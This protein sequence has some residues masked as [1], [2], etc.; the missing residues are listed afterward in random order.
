MVNQS[1]LNTYLNIQFLPQDV[2]SFFLDLGLVTILAFLLSKI[3]VKYGNSLSNRKAFSNNFIILG[4]T[5]M[6]IITVVKASL[7]LSLGLVGALSIVRFRSAIKEPEELAYLFLVISLG[8][9]I[10]AGQRYVTLLAFAFICLIL[11]LRGI[12]TKTYKEQNLFLTISS[13]S[14]EKV[15]LTQIVDTLK[16]SASLV[17]LRRSDRTENSMELVLYVRFANLAK[18]EKAEELLRSLDK[19]VKVSFVADKG[20]FS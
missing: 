13:N 6:F 14:L 8:L 20:I 17:I 3:Y 12:F 7:S 11:V 5:T 10:G 1:F 2:K 18:L 4:L 15:N 19:S 16:K 9:G